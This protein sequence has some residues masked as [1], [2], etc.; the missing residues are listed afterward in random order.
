MDLLNLLQFQKDQDDIVCYIKVFYINILKNNI[1]TI[2]YFFRFEL[3]LTLRA[4]IFDFVEGFFFMVFLF[5]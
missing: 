4:E 1:L 5:L 3:T 2:I